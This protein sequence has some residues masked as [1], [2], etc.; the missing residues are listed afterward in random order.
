[1]SRKAVESY[2]YTLADVA[3]FE[4]IYKRKQVITVYKQSSQQVEINSTADLW[5]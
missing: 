5:E 4:N 3:E 2:L 1:M